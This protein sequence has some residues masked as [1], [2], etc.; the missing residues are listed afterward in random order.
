[1]TSRCAVLA[2]AALIGACATHWKG[3]LYVDPPPELVDSG[4]CNDT[5][6]IYR[7]MPI[8]P[9]GALKG[10]QE[11]WVVM[12]FSVTEAGYP[13]DIEI[14]GSSPRG[15]FEQAALDSVQNSRYTVASF[16]REKCHQRVTFRVK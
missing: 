5:E 8:Y 6:P 10:R 13:A 11:G 15:I 7:P 2:L 3:S 14:I 16:K 4:T 9:K 12:L 1:M